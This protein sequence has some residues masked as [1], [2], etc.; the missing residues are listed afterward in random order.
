MRKIKK[1]TWIKSF[2]KEYLSKPGEHLI[3]VGITGSGKTQGLYWILDGLIKTNPDEMIVWFDTGKSGEILTLSKLKPLHVFIPYGT[4]L[5]TSKGIEI[6]VTEFTDLKMIWTDLKP[7]CINVICIEPFIIDPSTYTKVFTKLFSELIKLAHDYAIHTPMAIFVDEFNKIAPARGSTLDESQS[8]MGAVIQLN[9]ERL[10]SLKVRFVCATQGWT[11]IK[12][13][14]RNSFNWIFPR[15]GAHFTADQP[16]L[17]RFNPL[18]ETLD[19]GVG[20]L[21]FPTKVFTDTLH[22]PF[23]KEGK[24]LGQ[25]RYIGVFE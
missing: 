6:P 22:L 9:M 23:Y 24:D 16:K 11:K 12:S 17:Q 8:R 19:T 13:G 3:E 25:V 18:F 7:G 20:V 1:N 10:R 4:E 5:K 2:E 21:V 15:R 14:V